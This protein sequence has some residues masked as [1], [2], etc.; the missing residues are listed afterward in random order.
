MPG[1]AGAMGLEP[2]HGVGSSIT[3]QMEKKRIHKEDGRYLV[4]YHFPDTA[5]P[6]ETQAFAEVVPTGE[7]E[8]SIPAV[9]AE[10][11]Q[12]EHHV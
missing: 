2:L 6:E 9:P 5:G 7:P 8:P 1:G 4:Y 3:M 10:A 12:E 11:V